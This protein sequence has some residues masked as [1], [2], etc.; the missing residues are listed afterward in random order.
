MPE[1]AARK[2]A[3][4]KSVFYILHL[5]DILLYK[6]HTILR[7]AREGGR[8]ERETE[9]IIMTLRM[10]V[11]MVWMVKEGART[12]EAAVLYTLPFISFHG[13]IKSLL[14]YTATDRPVELEAWHYGPASIHGRAAE[15][16]Y[17]GRGCAWVGG[18][19]LSSPC[20]HPE[21]G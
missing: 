14:S 12:Q 10:M 7:G 3:G 19:V 11:M 1:E 13:D 17:S 20:T 18:T 21:A 16:H 6:T 15:T 4:P 8:E 9:M 2:R 5:H